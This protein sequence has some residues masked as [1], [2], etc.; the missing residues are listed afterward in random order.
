MLRAK[1]ALIAMF[2]MIAA[3]AGAM[4]LAPSQLRAEGAWCSNTY[5]EP[6]EQMCYW[7]MG[8]VCYLD[9]EWPFCVGWEKCGVT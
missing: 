4:T 3:V 5:C 7:N 1:V 8:T 6:G 2:T 9:G